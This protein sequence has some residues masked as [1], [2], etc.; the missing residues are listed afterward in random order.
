M[1]IDLTEQVPQGRKRLWFKR[2]NLR[3]H[4]SILRTL[5]GI[6]FAILDGAL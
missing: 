3:G 4:V 5:L 6:S 1:Q 2:Q